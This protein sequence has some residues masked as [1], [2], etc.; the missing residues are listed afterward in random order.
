MLNQN[1]DISSC[2]QSLCG[3]MN[4]FTKKK[5]KCGNSDTVAPFNRKWLNLT[6]P[7]WLGHLK[8]FWINLRIHMENYIKNKINDLIFPDLGKN[9]TVCSVDPKS[10]IY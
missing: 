2:C 5:A 3:W 6:F 9:R 4:F 1:R 10:C 7:D 8:K